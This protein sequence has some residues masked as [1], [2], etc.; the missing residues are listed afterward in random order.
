MT[1]FESAYQTVLQYAT[2]TVQNLLRSEIPRIRRAVN[3]EA[4]K[5]GEELGAYIEKQVAE[6]AVAVEADSKRARESLDSILGDL[7]N[8][9]EV[10]AR[11]I[12]EAV[13]QLDEALDAYEKK[14]RGYG[15]TLREVVKTGVKATGLPIPG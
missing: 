1:A 13:K 8:K 9:T 15:T 6:L 10:R 12:K 5:F 11:D 4:Q 2:P 7:K 3:D 14:W